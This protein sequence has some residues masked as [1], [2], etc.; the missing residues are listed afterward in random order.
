[1]AKLRNGEAWQDKVA[2]CMRS[3][4]IARCCGEKQRPSIATQRH[5]AAKPRAAKQRQGNAQ[6]SFGKAKQSSAWARLS[7]ARL[8]KGKAWSCAE[9]HGGGDALWRHAKQRRSMAEQW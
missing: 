8:S 4:G 9:R 5:G 7:C 6:M 2:L 1:M 3:S